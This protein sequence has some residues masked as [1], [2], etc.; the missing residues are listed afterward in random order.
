MKPLTATTKRGYRTDGDGSGH[1][2]PAIVVALALLVAAGAGCAPESGA[3]AVDADAEVAELLATADA[4]LASR[5]PAGLTAS[6]ELYQQAGRL[7]P[8]AARAHAG[9]ANAGCLLALYSLRPPAEVLPPAEAAAQEALRLAPDLAESWAALGLVDYLYHWDFERAEE[10]FLEASRLDPELAVVHHWRGMLLT[11]TSRHHE[12]V[13]A[14]DAALTLA[15]DSVLYR[16]KRAT[17]LARTGDRE[18]ARRELE[19]VLAAHPDSALA[20]RELGFLDLAENRPGAAVAALERAAEL[21]GGASKSQGG[22]GYAW[23]VT[24]R[25][26]AAREVLA[27]FHERARR[28]WV[29]PIYV[30]MMQG[31]LGEVDAAFAS[32]RRAVEARDPGVVYLAVRPGFEPLRGDP[33]FDDLLAEI[34]LSERG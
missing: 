18:A 25:A 7:D 27:A 16:T 32:L 9:A 12:S 8:S 10:R 23:A 11:A 17:V 5:T 33:R 14:F 15:P 1:Y 4:R 22:L 19:A 26:D 30:A 24:G 13:A 20:W 3:I 29:P 28:E 31:G 6:L 34:G 2:G 21:A